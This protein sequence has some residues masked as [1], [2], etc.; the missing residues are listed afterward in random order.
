MFKEILT[1]E[2]IE[3]LPLIKKF[4]KDYYMIGGT[5]IALNIGHRRSIDFELFPQKILRENRLRI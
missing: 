2:Q 1:K 4:S 5:A 3:L